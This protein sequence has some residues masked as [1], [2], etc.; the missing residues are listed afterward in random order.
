MHWE[1]EKITVINVNKNNTQPKFDQLHHN[2]MRFVDRIKTEVAVFLFFPGTIGMT[3]S[4]MGV[5]VHHV[6]LTVVAVTVG[7]LMYVVIRWAFF[8]GKERL[9]QTSNG[10]W[11]RSYDEAFH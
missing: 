3:M 9:G 1:E 4:I 6:F 11:R 7:F 10:M 2:A 5:A 8:D